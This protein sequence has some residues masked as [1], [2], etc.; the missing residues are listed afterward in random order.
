MALLPLRIY[1]DPVLKKKTESVA[2]VTA[3]IRQ[4]VED[5]ADTMYHSKGIGLAAPQVGASVRLFIMDLDW[6]SEE[7]GSPSGKKNLQVFINPV[8]VWESAEDCNMTEG[9]LS[10]PDVQGNV[11]RPVSVKIRAEDLEGRE[12]ELDLT[13]LPARCF[14]HEFDHLDGVLF[15]DR[16]PFIQR[17][18]IAGKLRLLKRRAAATAIS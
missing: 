13:D 3:E 4:L 1:G 6:V 17:Q 18:K 9:C 11:F 10:V 14:Q 12:R 2:G 7:G 5:M 15:V 8:V 16:M